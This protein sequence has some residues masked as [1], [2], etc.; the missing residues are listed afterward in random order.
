MSL[1]DLELRKPEGQNSRLLLDPGPRLAS[2]SFSCVLGLRSGTL[3]WLLHCVSQWSWP[4][5]CPKSLLGPGE[6]EEISV[7]SD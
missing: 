1:P 3:L 5:R 4:G 2:A 6:E 7:S